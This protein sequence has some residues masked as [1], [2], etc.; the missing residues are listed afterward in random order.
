MNSSSQLTHAALTAILGSLTPIRQESVKKITAELVRLRLS[1]ETID[2]IVAA[3]I[4]EAA[5]VQYVDDGGAVP[6][7]RESSVEL[8]KNIFT[9]K[10][11]TNN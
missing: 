6:P 7:P 11:Q 5:E 4:L 1:S 3:L 2:T 9:Q 10:K 8:L